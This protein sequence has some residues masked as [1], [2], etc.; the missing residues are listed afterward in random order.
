M[1]DTSG[2]LTC[3]F[4]D[5]GN[6]IPHSQLKQ[7]RIAVR[8]YLSVQHRG[9]TVS[10]RKDRRWDRGRRGQMLCGK[11]R[12]QNSGTAGK[13]KAGLQVAR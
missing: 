8:F 6:Q 5:M 7:P 2:F 1:K 4:P 10:Q 13:L 11:D 3:R 12:E 9:N